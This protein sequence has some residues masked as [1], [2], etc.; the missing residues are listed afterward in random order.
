MINYAFRLRV[1]TAIYGSQT[2]LAKSLGVTQSYISRLLRGK[3]S[4]SNLGFK[5]RKSI[6]SRWSYWNKQGGVQFR[7]KGKGTGNNEEYFTT[8]MSDIESSEEIFDEELEALNRQ[9]GV[10]NIGAVQARF[11]RFDPEGLKR[12]IKEYVSFTAEK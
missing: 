6:N 4:T 10:V 1:L 5:M 11:I 3:R 2:Q 12:G 9:Y 8:Q 7:V